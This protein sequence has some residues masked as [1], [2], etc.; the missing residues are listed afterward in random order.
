MEMERKGVLSRGKSMPESIQM[1]ELII[2]LY[3]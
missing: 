3:L 1:W 2:C